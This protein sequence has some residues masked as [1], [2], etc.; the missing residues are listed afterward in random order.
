MIEFC[1]NIHDHPSRLTSIPQ[2]AVVPRELLIGLDLE[3]QPK[4]EIE[5]CDV[6]TDDPL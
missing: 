5:G 4:M 3:M 2:H 1:S 6:C